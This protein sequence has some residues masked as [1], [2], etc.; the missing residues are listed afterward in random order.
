[1]EQ[2]VC[3]DRRNKLNKNMITII[4][5]LHDLEMGDAQSMF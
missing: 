4:K 2:D 3:Y 5:K 1:M